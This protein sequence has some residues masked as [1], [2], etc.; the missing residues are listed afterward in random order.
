MAVSLITA[1]T[2]IIVVILINS[3]TSIRKSEYVAL[4]ALAALQEKT[5]Y[6]EATAKKVAPDYLNLAQREETAFAFDAAER[7]LDRSLAFD[8]NNPEAWRLKFRM[9]LAQQRF[10]EAREIL[11]GE[12]GPEDNDA[13]RK[14]ARKESY[15][16]PVT[17]ADLPRLAADFL[18]HGMSGG[19]PR[20]FY[21]IN[22]NSFNAESHFKA[23]AE[24]LRLL[25]PN[26]ENLNFG[27]QSSE[28]GGWKIDLGNNPGL[29]DITPLCGLNIVQLKAGNIGT[30]DLELLTEE[31]MRSLDL[32]GTQ[33]THLFILDQFSRLEELDISRTR[34]RNL[35]NIDKYPKLHTLDI[36]QIEGL[37]IS[38]QLLW[39]RNLKLLTVARSFRDDPTILALAQRGVIIIYTDN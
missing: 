5:D 12:T 24:S 4:D 17:D 34:I 15:T 9:L 26:L 8:P 32:S 20:F 21:H 38:P 31:G 14:M 28:A 35:T 22:K 3:F 18:S 33:L 37:S 16:E 1:S 6:I 23:I 36:S 27:W 39:C 19:L 29:D 10:T 11:D 13:L 30:P 2:A 7:D 25:N